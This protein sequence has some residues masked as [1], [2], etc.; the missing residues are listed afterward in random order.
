MLMSFRPLLCGLLLFFGMGASFV[1]GCSRTADLDG[2]WYEQ[3]LNGGTITIDG[4]NMTYARGE[5]SD[6]T[7]FSV[8][9]S[10]KKLDI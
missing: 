10:A 8:K 2:V 7:K 5:Y 1:T 9:L 3:G 6:T 4:A